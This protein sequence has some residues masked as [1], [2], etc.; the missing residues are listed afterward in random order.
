[1]QLLRKHS[2]RIVK[3]IEPLESEDSFL[4]GLLSFTYLLFGLRLRAADRARADE[5]ELQEPGPAQCEAKCGGK[6]E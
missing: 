6:L 2:K 5:V 1:M 4:A 3:Y